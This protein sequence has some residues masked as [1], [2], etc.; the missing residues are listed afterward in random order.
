[1]EIKLRGVKADIDT[2]YD[3]IVTNSGYTAFKF[4]DPWIYSVT[5]EALGSGTGSRTIFFLANPYVDNANLLV[6]VGGTLKT[7]NTHYTVD[8]PCENGKIT[9]TGGNEPGN[10]V[11]VTATYNFYLKMYYDISDPRRDVKLTRIGGIVDVWE[12]DV[13]LIEVLS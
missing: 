12:L 10:G 7:L 9:F 3:L 6:Y 4:K 13:K 8:N 5:S 11:A 2:D 1:M